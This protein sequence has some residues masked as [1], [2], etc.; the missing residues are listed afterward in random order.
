MKNTIRKLTTVLL[1]LVMVL[2]MGVSTF[3]AGENT[4]SS[5]YKSDESKNNAYAKVDDNAFTITKEIV[6]FNVDESTIFDPN[7][8]YSYDVVPVDVTDGEPTVTG[9]I[10]D[11]PDENNP[12]KTTTAVVKDGIANAVKLQGRKENPITG[13]NGTA[14]T[15]RGA[16]ATSTTLTFGGDNGTK[17]AT[18]DEGTPITTAI[19]GNTGETQHQKVSTGYI[20]VSVDASVIYNANKGPGIYRYQIKDTTTDATLAA[21]GIKRDSN[22]VKDLY[23]DV[24][25]KNNAANNGYDVYGYVLHKGTS[26]K[27]IDIVYQKDNSETIKV[28][29]Y[30][31]LSEVTKAD[32]YHTY[33]VEVK[34]ATTGALADKRNNFPFKVTLSNS[35][36]TSLDDFYYVVTQ[37]GAAGNATTTNL[38]ADGSW[39]LGET[40]TNSAIKFQDGDGILITGLPV[41]TKV[42]VEEFNNLYDVYTASAKDEGAAV[43][44]VDNNNGQTNQDSVPL[45]SGKIAKLNVAK[46]VDYTDSK[47]IVAVTNN[48]E[49]ISPTNVVM[50]Y[51]PYLFIL[52]AGMMLLLVSRRRKSEEE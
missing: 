23:L 25:V 11:D 18:L 20:D 46:D 24:Y 40:S 15:V 19:A 28:D 32:Q 13:T 30:T 8:V 17:Y 43:L 37:D 49:T 29:G 31:V 14:G 2:A 35:V 22:Y 51:A 4:G 16:N 9:I 36:V 45:E 5:A 52:G 27:D 48:I 34:K 26:D 41:S 39:I 50:R 6:L 38:L 1:A 10:L 47:D 12:H 42:M 44:K 3:A 21:A 7:V 33:N